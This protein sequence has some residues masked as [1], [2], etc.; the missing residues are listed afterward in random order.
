MSSPADR[1]A[2]ASPVTFAL[3]ELIACWDQAYTALV[4]GDLDQ[5]AALLDVAD[6][7]LTAAGSGRT[8]S[9]DE[10]RLRDTAL[11]SRGRLEHGMGSGLA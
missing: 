11:G 2:T 10:A 6:G 7:H 3:R 9:P 8:D 1:Y 4:Q 5:V